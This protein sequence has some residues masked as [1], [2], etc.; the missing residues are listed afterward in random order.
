[1][2]FKESLK[3]IFRRENWRTIAI[4]AALFGF[5]WFT[6]FGDQG[7]L[8]LRRSSLLK[9][10]LNQELSAQRLKIE[11]L[12]KDKELLE[13]RD[14]LELTIRQELGYVKPGEV[15]FKANEPLTTP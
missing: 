1:M 12:K 13:N 8:K 7:L 3:N 4:F 5:L 10:Q 6:I 15:V 11:K 14:H 2:K 9:N